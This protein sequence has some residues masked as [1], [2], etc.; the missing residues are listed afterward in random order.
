MV[1]SL[2][3]LR[4]RL[5]DPARMGELL[6]FLRRRNCVAEQ[7]DRVT[8]EVWPP[9]L[10]HGINGNGNGA[11]GGSGAER[12]HC[13]CCGGTVEEAL[14]RLGSSRCHDCRDSQPLGSPLGGGLNGSA[15]GRLKRARHEL[16]SHLRTWR[17]ATDGA[18]ALTD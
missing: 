11:S 5:V 2:R 9:E 15:R 13:T 12:L 7:V 17:A 6:E 16:Q 3:P 8:I 18:A 10:L 4:I 14:W 1:D